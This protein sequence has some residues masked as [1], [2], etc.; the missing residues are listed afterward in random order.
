MRNKYELVFWIKE[1]SDKLAKDPMQSSNHGKT[2]K[3][4]WEEKLG[5]G[6]TWGYSEDAKK[7]I[8]IKEWKK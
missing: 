5:Y 2:I 8:Y 7:W 6:F 1:L 4:M 3:K